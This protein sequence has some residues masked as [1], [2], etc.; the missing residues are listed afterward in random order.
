L[1][2]QTIYDPPLNP[3]GATLEEVGL[4]ESIYD[5]SLNPRGASYEQL[6][7]LIDT[8]TDRRYEI[9]REA[10]RSWDKVFR[11]NKGK[12]KDLQLMEPGYAESHAA[13]MAIWNAGQKAIQFVTAKFQQE[14]LVP[15]APATEVVKLKIGVRQ[16]AGTRRGGGGVVPVYRSYEVPSPSKEKEYRKV[17]QSA[18]K[19]RAKRGQEP[20]Q[21]TA[22][23]ALLMD[24]QEQV[25]SGE[26]QLPYRPFMDVQMPPLPLIP[27]KAVRRYEISKEERRKFDR[28]FRQNKD[29]VQAKGTNTEAYRAIYH[30]AK[31]AVSTTRAKFQQEGLVPPAPAVEKVKIILSA[32]SYVSFDVPSP[33]TEQQYIAVLKTALK[34]RKQTAQRPIQQTP[35]R[36]FV[37]GGFAESI[38]DPSLNPRGAKLSDFDDLADLVGIDGFGQGSLPSVRATYAYPYEHPPLEGFRLQHGP[39]DLTIDGSIYDPPLNP[40]GASLQKLGLADDRIPLAQKLLMQEEKIWEEIEKQRAPA[41]YTPEGYW[42]KQYGLE[43]ITQRSYDPF[44]DLFTPDYD[45]FMDITQREYDPFMDVLAFD[46]DPFM[47]GL[48]GTKPFKVVQAKEPTT[49]VIRMWI[50][51]KGKLVRSSPEIYTI[52]WMGEVLDMMTTGYK[53]GDLKPS[54]AE[55]RTPMEAYEKYVQQKNAPNVG[56]LRFRAPA[57]LIPHQGQ[58]QDAHG[59]GQMKYLRWEPVIVQAKPAPS[60][61]ITPA[62][63]PP[64]PATGGVTTTVTTP[65][66]PIII[67]PG[68][69]PQQMVTPEEQKEEEEESFITAFF[70]RIADAIGLG[71]DTMENRPYDDFMDGGAWIHIFQAKQSGVQMPDLYVIPYRN[72]NGKRTAVITQDMGAAVLEIKHQLA[73]GNVMATGDKIP[74]PIAEGLQR[75]RYRQ[76]FLLKSQYITF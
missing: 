13:H 63:A 45:P 57:A 64:A 65:T 27:S 40:R 71:D 8:R 49:Y 11:A 19:E 2:K 37:V 59:V 36:S 34:K 24:N 50:E 72:R 25:W 76:Q 23:R 60:A 58:V 16:T 54:G 62:V 38:Y 33:S 53:K 48:S 75:R 51:E 70:K 35:Y 22:Y 26:G 5:P 29:E 41:A 46:Y 32:W 31:D 12:V 55:G 15:P 20:I 17:M 69:G 47:G 30:A 3:R 9:S 18:L 56:N 61:A 21:Q 67:P 14:G 6:G 74:D 44:M 52:P 39:V 4:A 68:P 7:R 1:T 28:V 10:R 66:E 42:R 43:D 73:A